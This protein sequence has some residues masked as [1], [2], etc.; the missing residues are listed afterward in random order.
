M[1]FKTG[2]VVDVFLK[3][4]EHLRVEIRL[5][6]DTEVDY[7]FSFFRPIP[8]ALFP[9]SL[10]TNPFRHVSFPPSLPASI[11]HNLER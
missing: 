5:L 10:S 9:R 1:Q 7:I 2:E 4:N 6:M 11:L 8:L 3:N